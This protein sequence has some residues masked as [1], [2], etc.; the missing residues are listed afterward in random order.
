MNTTKTR[1]LPGAALLL[2]LA[3]ALLGLALIL[4]PAAQA[5]AGD[6]SE[7]EIDGFD[8]Y[9]EWDD[10]W[11]EGKA[12]FHCEYCSQGFGREFTDGDHEGCV[13]DMIAEDILECGHCTECYMEYHCVDCHQ[14]FES[15]DA[16]SIPEPKLD[17]PS[18]E[19]LKSFAEAIG[20]SL[21]AD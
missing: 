8:Y 14:C 21:S 15:G 5:A 11:G 19:S 10:E 2:T 1:T 16:E 17:L 4:C 12:F 3:A 20:E 6:I 18:E 13:E 9:V 7:Y